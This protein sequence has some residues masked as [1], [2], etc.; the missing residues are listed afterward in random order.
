M[1]N[2]LLLIM[3]CLALVA[4]MAGCGS[5]KGGETATQGETQTVTQAGQSVTQ[6]LAEGETQVV[7][8]NGKEES[9]DLSAD[10]D[11]VDKP[12]LPD[13][14]FTEADA[15]VDATDNASDNSTAA[16]DIIVTEAG[17][18][19]AEKDTE[20]EEVEPTKQVMDYNSKGEGIVLPDDVWE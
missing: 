6:T 12:E 15:K 1:R 20:P 16:E 3:L 8:Q 13:D 4:V 18:E 19:V 14:A 10:K 9:A 7:P 11:A 17:N 2:K 5:A